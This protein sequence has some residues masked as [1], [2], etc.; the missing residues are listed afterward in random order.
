MSDNNHECE[1]WEIRLKTP[2]NLDPDYGVGEGEN[3]KL[4]P[5]EPAT[6]YD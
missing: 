4:S 3:L 1:N 2:T 5:R 6:R